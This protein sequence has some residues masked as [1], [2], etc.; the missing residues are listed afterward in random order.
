MPQCQPIQT[1]DHHLQTPCTC[2][3]VPPPLPPIWR[4]MQAARPI[5]PWGRT[6]PKVRAFTQ[7]NNILRV[8]FMLRIQNSPKE[9]GELPALCNT[10]L[11]SSVHWA[12]VRRVC[13]QPVDC[14]PLRLTVPAFRGSD[15]KGDGHAVKPAVLSS[16]AKLPNIPDR[17]SQ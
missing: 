4:E 3:K 10:A 7:T 2:L 6:G 5:P 13:R 15:Q 17:V 16:R 12:P 8:N 9:V 1:D 14:Q 11:M